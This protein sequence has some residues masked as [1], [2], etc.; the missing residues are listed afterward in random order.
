MKKWGE[1]WCTGRAGVR[2]T[3]YLVLRLHGCY[4]GAVMW[5]ILKD[6]DFGEGGKQR[7]EEDAR[8]MGE[9]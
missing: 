7:S 4:Y 5:E 9:R 1:Y 6:S 2:G 8:E 3:A